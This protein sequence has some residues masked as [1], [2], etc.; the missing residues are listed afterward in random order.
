MAAVAV[1]RSLFLLA[2]GLLTLL[3]R[4]SLAQVHGGVK[5]GL[6]L[7]TLD[8]S[9]NRRSE[10]RPAVHGGLY[11]TAWVGKQ[12]AVQPEVLY[13]E[14]GMKFG[15]SPTGATDN[16]LRLQVIDIPLLLKVYPFGKHFFA[17]V[18]PQFGLLVGAEEERVSSGGAKAVTTELKRKYKNSDY[19]A[20]A[21]LGVEAG[22]LLLGVRGIYGLSDLNNDPTEAAFRA[23]QGLGGLH[24]RLLQVS[25]GIR[26][27]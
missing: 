2:I 4:T 7:A 23:A 17:E 15:L 6:N 21:G 8:G 26:I 11:L 5:G 20:V 3:P 24:H 22:R 16:T 9:I 25:A 12:V 14:Q 27:F 13:S 10:V 19:A 18:G 1:L